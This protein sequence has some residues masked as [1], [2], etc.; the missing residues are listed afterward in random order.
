MKKRLIE[1][2]TEG[3]K[4]SEYKRALE[5]HAQY[6]ADEGVDNDVP[7]EINE[8]LYINENEMDEKLTATWAYINDIDGE[9][10]ALDN[11]IRKLQAKKKSRQREKENLTNYVG[12]CLR[13]YGN[14]NDNG[15]HY[16][17]NNLFKVTASASS[18]VEVYDENIIPN[19]FKSEIVTVKVDK[20]SIRKLL[21]DG[22]EI[23]GCALD[24][25][26][27]NVNFR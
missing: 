18:K 27:I 13:L 3:A 19:D 4:L 8:R 23:E 11:M 20:A 1:I 14:K 12:F 9:I 16:F 2:V 10:Y 6:C 25:S 26:K 15:N 22:H 24:Q 17:K 5:E 7:D 21:M